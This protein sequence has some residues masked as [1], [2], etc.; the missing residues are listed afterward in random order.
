VALSAAA[1][2]ASCGGGGSAD[3][4]TAAGSSAPTV[5]A[6]SSASA[7]RYWQPGPGTSWQWQLT[8]KVDQAY[9]VGVYDIDGF[10]NGADVV[11]SLHAKKRKVICYVDVGSSENFRP[12][13]KSFPASVQGKSNGWEG[14]RW[15][16]VRNTSV[17]LPLMAK[18]FDMCRAKGFDA[19]EPDNVDGYS[20]ATGFPLKAADQLRFNRAI[21]K[22]AHDRGLSVG[23]KNDIEQ[24]PQLVG[25]FQFAVNEQ[26]AE[27]DECGSLTPFVQ[28]KKAVFHVEYNLETSQFCAKTTALG[29]SSLRKNLDLD[30]H[31]EAC[32]T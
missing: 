24:I 12:D 14:E 30:A 18:R 20:N 7:R 10:T 15:L 31:R 8:G 25:D 6:E 13:F 27:Y 23:L 21:A 4:P 19:V 9:D 17:L 3:A 22:L 16:D 11:A 28:A 5:T 26:C 29:L 2:L 1:A 32:P